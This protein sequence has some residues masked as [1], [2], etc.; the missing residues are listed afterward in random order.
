MDYEEMV[1]DN[2]QHTFRKLDHD[3]GRESCDTCKNGAVAWLFNSVRY[4]QHRW[5]MAGLTPEMDNP[6]E[7]AF[8]QDELVDMYARLAAIFGIEWEEIS[9]ENT[10][11]EMFERYVMLMQEVSSNDAMMNAIRRI[12]PRHIHFFRVPPTETP[13]V[14]MDRLK[15][16]FAFPQ[17]YNPKRK[18]KKK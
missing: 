4:D 12:Q 6:F 13:K 15:T 14:A 1:S 17:L 3:C 2:G 5:M 8:Q 9:Q 16:L 10:W 11:H 18:A 7:E